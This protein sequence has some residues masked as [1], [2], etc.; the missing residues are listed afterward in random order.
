MSQRKG[1]EPIS[2]C[3]LLLPNR[4]KKRL[5]LG[6]KIHYSTRVNVIVCAI[7]DFFRSPQMDDT[8]FFSIITQHGRVDAN[9][10]RAVTEIQEEARLGLGS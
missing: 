4:G 5:G 10:K 1:S 3:D 8:I 7:Y 9:E 6:Y 2:D